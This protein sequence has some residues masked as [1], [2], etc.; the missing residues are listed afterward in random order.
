MVKM[1]TVMSVN[2]RVIERHWFRNYYLKLKQSTCDTA[3]D[4]S[5]I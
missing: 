2:F 3:K 4:E 5:E 1:L